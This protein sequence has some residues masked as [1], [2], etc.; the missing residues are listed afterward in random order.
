[1]STGYEIEMYHNIAAIAQALNRIANCMEA[2]EKRARDM[3]ATTPEDIVLMMQ[4]VQAVR[5]GFADM[6]ASVQK[7]G[8]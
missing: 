3:A 4:G 1:M 6:E 8:E 2:A 7:E 5:R